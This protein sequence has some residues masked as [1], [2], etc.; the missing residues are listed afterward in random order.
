[1]QLSNDKKILF[2]YKNSTEPIII[3]SD[4]KYTPAEVI[5]C[6]VNI[7]NKLEDIDKLFFATEYFS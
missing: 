2:F 1:M 7:E 3:F 6:C 5:N 4:N